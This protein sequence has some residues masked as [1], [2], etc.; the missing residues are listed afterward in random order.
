MFKKFFLIVFIFALGLSFFYPSL[1]Q[2]ETALS[3]EDVLTKLKEEQGVKKISAIDC[4]KLTDGQFEE[5]GE[6]AMNVM[7]PN[8]REHEL[9]DQ[10]MGGE[11]SESLTAM[12]ILMGENYLGCNSGAAGY[13]GMMGSGGMMSMMGPGNWS[14]YPWQNNN[15]MMNNNM[16]GNFGSWSLF[17]WIFM[18]L[19]WILLILAI[20]AIIKWLANQAGGEPK[21]KSAL[22]ILKERYARGEI[23]KEEFEQKSREIKNN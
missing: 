12:H 5:L 3:V 17:G 14:N 23:S 6:A 9:M 16:M 2:E 21:G 11:G 20:V 10:M 15:N 19:F 13:G 4:K 22:D 18:L 1:A 7:H 8:E